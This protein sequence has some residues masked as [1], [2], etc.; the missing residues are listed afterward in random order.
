MLKTPIEDL[1]LM[2]NKSHLTRSQNRI[3]R[4]A[5][6]LCANDNERL[7]K[8]DEAI[9]RTIKACLRGV[10]YHKRKNPA[11]QFLNELLEARQRLTKTA[12]TAEEVAK[13]TPK[14]GV[15]PMD[16]LVERYLQEQKN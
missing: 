3:K 2:G 5:A 15:D 13:A 1:E 10:S 12:K 6:P 9:D 7:Q 14:K 8:L 4:Q 16:E 11:G